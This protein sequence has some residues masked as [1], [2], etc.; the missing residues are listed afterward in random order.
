MIPRYDIEYS[1][2]REVEE[3][4]QALSAPSPLVRDVHVELADRYAD[5]AWSGRE[6]RCADGNPC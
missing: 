6:S 3:R 5:R 2:R 4:A 1:L